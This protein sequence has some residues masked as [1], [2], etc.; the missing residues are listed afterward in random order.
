M[1]AGRWDCLPP[2]AMSRRVK[3]SPPSSSLWHDRAASQRQERR[4]TIRDDVLGPV[5]TEP[6]L[7]SQGRETSSNTP[8]RAQPIGQF[9]LAFDPQEKITGGFLRCYVSLSRDSRGGGLRKTAC[10]PSDPAAGTAQ[11]GSALSTGRGSL[12]A[13]AW[14]SCRLAGL[15]WARIATT[16]SAQ[17]IGGCAEARG[18]RAAGIASG[19]GSPLLEG[20]EEEGRQTAL[21]WVASLAGWARISFRR[22]GSWSRSLQPPPTSARTRLT[23]QGVIGGDT[24]RPAIPPRSDCVRQ[25]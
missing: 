11:I 25:R 1:R 20:P 10:R 9:S 17:T 3:R 4:P 19:R 16:T 7:R 15:P 8:A 13:A 21:T 18:R 2:S 23:A 12:E 6:R 14:P 22:A 5:L 24:R